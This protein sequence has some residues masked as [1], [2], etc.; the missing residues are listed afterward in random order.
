MGDNFD[1]KY[2]QAVDKIGQNTK[3]NYE[4]LIRRETV[5]NFF[6]NFT[7]ISNE[8]EN[9]LKDRKFNNPHTSLIVTLDESGLKTTD[10]TNS[11]IIEN[12][13]NKYKNVSAS[14]STSNLVFKGMKKSNSVLNY[15]FSKTKGGSL[16]NSFILNN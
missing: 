9:K 16:K 10:R 1:Q 5:Q 8:N 7:F 14:S 4:N 3:E 2:C 11:L 15:N 12:K 13:L 6:K